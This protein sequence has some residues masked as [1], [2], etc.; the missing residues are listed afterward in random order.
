M[1]DTKRM[2]AALAYVLWPVALILLIIEETQEKKDR[3]LRYHAYNALGF[4]VAALIIAIPVMVLAWLP[5]LG[6]VVVTLFWIAF[7]V[8]A[9]IYA[10]RAYK[11]QKVVIPVVTDFLKRNVKGL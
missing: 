6:G 10:L 7:V 8:L 4:A 3:E 5:I 11:G 2:L 9:I 1:D